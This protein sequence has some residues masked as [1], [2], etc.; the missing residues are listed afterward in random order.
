M[1]IIRI[2]KKENLENL[3]Q[4]L[5]R[6]NLINCPTLGYKK[7]CWQYM[8][9]PFYLGDELPA[10]ISS[11][12][13]KPTGHLGTLPI[14]LK[15][16]SRKIIAAWA[17]DFMT[18]SEY[19][20][21]G[22]GRSL[23]DEANRCLDV[24]LT[25]GQTDK[26]FSLFTKMGWKFLGNIPYYIK[27]LDLKILI[28]EKIKNLFIS[29][30][31]VVPVNLFLKVFNYLKRPRKPKGIEI[32]R[33]ANFNE[34]A[35]LFWEEIASSYKIIVPRNK[36]YLGWKYDAQPGMDYVKFRAVR[37][38]KVSGYIIVH[39]IRTLGR[40]EGLITDII[41]RPKD[42]DVVRGLVFAALEY[43]KSE[44]CSIIRCYINQKDIQGVLGSCGFM[45]RES[46]LRFLMNKNSDG[47]EETYNLDNW[48]ITAG[49]CDID[50]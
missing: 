34:E 24:F 31:V 18:S 1:N 29:N 8:E 33:I 7:W 28:K 44:D 26:A 10:W 35:D 5:I 32:H 38:D 48:Y 19:R 30:L 14:E 4:D 39:C 46:R 16:G 21:K 23:V 17:V 42:K 11:L 45:K 40:K 6:T 49:D 15:V 12:D 36:A 50:R 37:K 22:I 13:G 2:S 41:S 25:V 3:F 9:N 47:L 43:L 20:R 27:I